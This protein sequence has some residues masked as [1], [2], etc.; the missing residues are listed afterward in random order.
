MSSWGKSCKHW[1][2]GDSYKHCPVCGASSHFGPS[3]LRSPEILLGLPYSN[4][5]DMWSAGCV[6]AHLFLQTNLFDVH[7]EYEMVT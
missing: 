2:T 3:L 6:L 5:I 4:A 7:S 1:D